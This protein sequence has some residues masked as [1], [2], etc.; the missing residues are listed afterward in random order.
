MTTV[1][2]GSSLIETVVGISLL[3]LVLVGVLDAS[4]TSI[5]VAS[6]THQNVIASA[7]LNESLR[8]LQGIDY[9]PCPQNDGAYRTA[10]ETRVRGQDSPPPVPLITR[11]E[12]WSAT[13]SSW[14]DFTL[15]ESCSN[16]PDLTEPHAAQRL[17][18]SIHGL[19]GTMASGAIVKTHATEE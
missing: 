1:D 3:G 5:R 6:T 11:Y 15:F 16:T 4:W 14:V 19:L 10:L 12:Y 18:V 9:S 7:M 2:S 13:T 8:A 17:T